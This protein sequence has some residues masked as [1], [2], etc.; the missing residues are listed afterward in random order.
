M[1]AVLTV[2]SVP[3]G[4][5]RWSRKTWPVPPVLGM[6]FCRTDDRFDETLL[7]LNRFRNEMNCAAALG[8]SPGTA[9]AT[10]DSDCPRVSVTYRTWERAPNPPRKPGIPGAGRKVG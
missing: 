3:V 6:K 4:L 7:V 1:L 5:L 9:N 8:T 2:V 10:A